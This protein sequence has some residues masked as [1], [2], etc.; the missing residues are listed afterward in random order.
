MREEQEQQGSG[1]DWTWGVM[2]F[3]VAGLGG[4]AMY[5]ALYRGAK[6]HTSLTFIGIPLVLAVLLALMPKT[7]S[8]TGG[9]VRGI[10][11]ALLIIAP[12]LGEGY[13]CILMA[14]PLFYLVG[15]P[16]GLAVDHF[17]SRRYK[18]LCVA[19]LVFVP[20]SMEGTLPELTFPREQTVEATRIV[21]ATPAEVEVALSR[22]QRVDERLPA[23]LRV[24]FPRPIAS[25]GA[26][27]SL[28]DERVVRFSGAEGDP[29][30]DLVSRVAA[31]GS[32]WVRF[33]TV[34]DAS[35]LRQWVRWESSEVE[36]HAVDATHTQVT[37]RIR[38]ARQLDPAWYFT[39]WERLAAHQAAAY[40]IAANATP[41]TGR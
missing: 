33:E 15:V 16:I 9:I 30:G 11:L 39:P 1:R 26:G 36:W 35:K 18:T 38:F 10:T 23:F 40:L 17:R 2:G 22:P 32:G 29:A 37:W 20:M 21:A 13:L 41:E 6:F 12:L 31:R 3:L 27:L 19:A 7:K 8:T 25:S 34:S 28:G 24:G 4:A 14:A 5:L